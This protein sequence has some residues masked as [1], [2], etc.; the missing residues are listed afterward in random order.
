MPT[1]WAIRTPESTGSI[2]ATTKCGGKFLLRLGWV[3]LGKT[4]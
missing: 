4:E 3:G 1:K 2:T